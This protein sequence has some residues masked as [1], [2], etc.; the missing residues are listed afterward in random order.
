[1][2][3]YVDGKHDLVLDQAGNLVG[4]H[5]RA[6]LVALH[7]AEQAR[8]ALG[9][10]HL[11]HIYWLVDQQHLPYRKFGRELVFTE[12]DIQEFLARRGPR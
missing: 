8:V 9:Y 2:G 4:F 10:A 11:R 6:G 3:R 7:T 5:G 12:S 1:M